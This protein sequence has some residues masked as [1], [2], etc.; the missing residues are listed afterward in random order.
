MVLED[1]GVPRLGQVLS[2]ELD[3]LSTELMLPAQTV[4][5]PETR[6]QVQIRYGRGEGIILEGDSAT[7]HDALVRVA[8][9]PEVQTWLE[10]STRHYAQLRLGELALAAG[11]PS[12]IERSVTFHQGEAL[13]AGKISPQPALLRFGARITEEGGADVPA[14]WAAIR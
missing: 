10:R 7:F 14:T 9:G 3:Q 5:A 12:L 2:L 1:G 8:T 11:V 4:G 13:I 6:T